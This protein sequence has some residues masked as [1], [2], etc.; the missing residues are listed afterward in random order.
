VQRGLPV[1]LLVKHFEQAGERWRI[2]P[3]LRRMVNFRLFNLLDGTAAMGVFDVIF[4]RNVLI[5]FDHPT[6]AAVL[7]RLSERLAQDGS[8]ILGGAESVFGISNL[9][10]G[11][12]RLRGVYRQASA[13]A[14]PHNILHSAI[15]APKRK[16]AE[17]G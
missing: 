8:L 11:V 1:H 5:Y 12:D 2:K 14:M 16:V 6:K 9:F 7:G 3:E 17:L 10:T 15:N 13:R 4:C